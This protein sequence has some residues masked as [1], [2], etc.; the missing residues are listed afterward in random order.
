MNPTQASKPS[1]TDTKAD[2][3]FRRVF[4]NY[5]SVVGTNVG[6]GPTRFSFFVTPGFVPNAATLMFAMVLPIRT[7]A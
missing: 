5:L 1:H 2:L 4:C 6:C 3:I 7:L